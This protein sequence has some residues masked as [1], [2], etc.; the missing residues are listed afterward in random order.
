MKGKFPKESAVFYGE[1]KTVEAFTP[2]DF[3]LV[4]SK[5]PFSR[6]VQFIQGLYIRDRRLLKWN[7][8][9]II[10]NPEGELVEADGKEIKLGSLEEY[11]YSDYFLIRLDATIEDRHQAVNFA[12][13]TVGEK[14][15]GITRVLN[16]LSFLTALKISVGTKGHEFCSG[17]I[18]KCLERTA[19][20]FPKDASHTTPHDLAQYYI[21]TT[22]TPDERVAMS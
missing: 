14:V 1:G 8:C 15:S 12:L 19:A 5:A 22:I 6:F 21:D 20:I 7:H 11:K 4:A 16:T 3:I 2:G 13:A 18:V 9:A 10:V 17:L